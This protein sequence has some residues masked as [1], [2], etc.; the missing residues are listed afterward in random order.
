MDHR[1]WIHR[2]KDE[3]GPWPVLLFLHGIGEAAWALRRKE[4]KVIEQS[5]EAVRAHGSPPDLFETSD[6]R[7]RQLW[8]QFVLVSPQAGNTPDTADTWNWIDD[9][10]ARQVTRA[11]EEAFA[12]G[13]DR[14]R[15]F[16]MGFSRG[17]KGCLDLQRAAHPF[18]KVV[19]L[20]AEKLASLPDTQCPVWLHWA[21]STLDRIERAHRDASNAGLVAV[22]A[23]QS[24]AADARALT[25]RQVDIPPTDKPKR[26]RT[27]RH[28]ALCRTASADA[29]IYAW[30]IS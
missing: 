28:T 25:E 29:D 26:A 12:Q 21:R 11:L 30:L 14:N 10:I 15:V 16:A 5:R 7:V 18:A 2:P 17:G 4:Q 27:L 20:D 13:G 23:G 3:R 19:T 1:P 6:P 22:P 24:P 9:A 8:T